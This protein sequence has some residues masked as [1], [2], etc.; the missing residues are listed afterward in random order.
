[1]VPRS[2]KS[3]VLFVTLAAFA[4]LQGCAHKPPAD[5][6][7]GS[8][9]ED[10]YTKANTNPD[11]DV[12]CRAATSHLEQ[13]E[14][15]IVVNEKKNPLD[16]SFIY[17]TAGAYY[18]YAYCCLE[19]TDQ[20]EAMD[21]YLKGRNLALSELRRYS[22]FDQAFDDDISRYRKALPYNFDK[23]NLP[24]LYWT[25]MNWLG[26]IGLNR[27]VPA[28]SD[29]VARIEAMLEFINTIDRSYASG[30]VHA[31]L[32]A[33]YAL[34]SKEDGGDPAKAKEQFEAA[35]LY[36]GDSLLMIHVMYARF[37]AVRMQDRELFRSTLQKVLDTPAD[38]YPE[39]TFVNEVAKR[40]ARIYL[41]KMESFFAAPQEKKAAPGEN[42][43]EPG[44]S[45]GEPA[46]TAS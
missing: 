35:V 19:D 8:Y 29:S 11:V 25:A 4:V 32:G 39:K 24:A 15:L 28:F 20:K 1:M 9:L 43:G 37:Y 18:G 42:Q 22:F 10:I 44:E 6:P 14:D 5:Q 46:G 3:V 21:N 27:D 7:L 33:A 38:T 2:W 16:L 34:R 30:T 23:R 36:S 12:F 13:M 17:R 45:S 40:K 41:E 26:W 31:A